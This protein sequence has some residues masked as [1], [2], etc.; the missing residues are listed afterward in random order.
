MQDHQQGPGTERWPQTVSEKMEIAQFHLQKNLSAIGK[1]IR[2]TSKRP[3]GEPRL[4]IRSAE[5]QT[6][7]MKIFVISPAGRA[8]ISA[9]I[10]RKQ[11]P[12]ISGA[13]RSFV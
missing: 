9:Q 2:G 10:N 1:E 8:D 13:E 11:S 4:E 7:L 5:K 3:K 12:E 6:I